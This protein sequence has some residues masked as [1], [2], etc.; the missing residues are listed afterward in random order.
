MPEDEI[1]TAIGSIS[2]DKNACL[3]DFKSRVKLK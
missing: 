2:Y 3:K 1:E